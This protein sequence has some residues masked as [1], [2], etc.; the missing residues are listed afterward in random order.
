MCGDK[1]SEISVLEGSDVTFIDEK[2]NW[3]HRKSVVNSLKNVKIVATGLVI[4]NIQS[5]NSQTYICHGGGNWE[6]KLT[7]VKGM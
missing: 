1:K 3:S 4:S 7:A 5:D 2:C 6:F